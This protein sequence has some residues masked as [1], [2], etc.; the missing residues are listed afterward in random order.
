MFEYIIYF[1]NGESEITAHDNQIKSIRPIKSKHNKSRRN[2]MKK[3]TRETLRSE[4][5][6]VGKVISMD[7]ARSYDE[8]DATRTQVQN[9]TI[10]YSD[11]EMIGDIAI[12]ITKESRITAFHSMAVKVAGTLEVGDYVLLTDCIEQKSDYVNKE[13]ATRKIKDI[14]ANQVNKI[15]EEIYSKVKDVILTDNEKKASAPDFT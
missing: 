15:S 12:P 2:I 6:A 11:V 9:F 3:S 8:K 1:R 10:E 5:K 14:I 13:G 4:F 7:K